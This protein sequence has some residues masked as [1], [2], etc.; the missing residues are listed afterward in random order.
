MMTI[1]SFI[2]GVFKTQS[3]H[4]KT[5]SGNCRDLDLLKGLKFR[6]L[7]HLSLTLHTQKKPA[8]FMVYAY[9]WCWKE[10]DILYWGICF[11]WCLTLSCW[12][13]YILISY[14]ELSDRLTLSPK[15]VFKHYTIFTL[16]ECS[17]RMLKCEKYHMCFLWIFLDVLD[18]FCFLYSM[19]KSVCKDYFE[20]NT[21]Q[22][23]C[24]E[25]SLIQAQKTMLLFVSVWNKLGWIKRKT[26]FKSHSIW[27][28]SRIQH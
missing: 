11:S 20:C 18:M 16:N 7:E 26:I 4:I 3:G 8:K 1:K 13:H 14:H 5:C 22:Y 27:Y 25:L 17:D 24:I 15:A 10:G 6:H 28:C 2:L 23:K 19:V 12:S 21:L 9:L